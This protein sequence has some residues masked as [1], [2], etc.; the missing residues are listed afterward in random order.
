MREAWSRLPSDNCDFFLWLQD[1]CRY[2][3]IWY[4][5]RKGRYLPHRLTVLTGY[6]AEELN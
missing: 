2:M 4:N 5:L 3:H 1:G 6:D